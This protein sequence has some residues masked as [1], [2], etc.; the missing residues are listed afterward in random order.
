MSPDDLTAGE[1]CPEVAATYLDALK[2]LHELRGIFKHS[3][4]ADELQRERRQECDAWNSK[5][6]FPIEQWRDW[7]KE[8][9]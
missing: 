6:V 1:Q 8:R 4:M 3:G 2:K 5:H 7:K 9:Q